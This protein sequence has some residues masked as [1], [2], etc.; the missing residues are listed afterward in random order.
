MSETSPAS[1]PP[2]RRAL[3]WSL[4]L[5]VR[6][7]TDSRYGRAHIGVSALLGGAYIYQGEGLALLRLD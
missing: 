3:V 1:P 2:G 4:D 5:A 6:R 7:T